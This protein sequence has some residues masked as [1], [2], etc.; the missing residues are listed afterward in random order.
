MPSVYSMMK[1][2]CTFANR[3]DEVKSFFEGLESRVVMDVKGEEPFYLEFSGGRLSVQKGTPPQFDATIKSE[4]KTMDD[5]IAGK[6][7]QED[8]FN[9]RLIETSGS[10]Q[11]AMRV[12]YV[13][14]QT[15]QQSK[16]LGLF[17][18]VLGAFK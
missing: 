7:S 5:I 16:T 1:T 12:R 17:Q 18:K 10:I 11:D 4:K 13:L 15:L 6:L 2:L 8:A 3:S 9:R 14:N